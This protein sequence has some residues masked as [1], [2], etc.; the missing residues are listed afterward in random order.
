MLKEPLALVGMSCRLPGGDGLEEF[1]KLVAQGATSWGSLPAD[2]LD[3]GLYFGVEKGTVGKSYSELGGLVSDR[4][5]DRSVCP[6]TSDQIENY[7]GHTWRN[8][9]LVE[10]RRVPL[11]GDPIAPPPLSHNLLF[12]LPP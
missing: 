4:P 10:S 5:V 12:H 11:V 1:W 2:R 3:R 8:H 9:M 6:L 7:E